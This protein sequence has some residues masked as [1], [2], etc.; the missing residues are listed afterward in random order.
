VGLKP[1]PGRSVDRQLESLWC[2]G[3]HDESECG[4]ERGPR[5]GDCGDE[6][7]PFYG[8]CFTAPNVSVTKELERR[9]EI[10]PFRESPPVGPPPLEAATPSLLTPRNSDL[11]T[12]GGTP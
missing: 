6:H 9:L 2:G 4:N 10:P 12:P 7:H 3:R 11:D 8:C 5:R 1:P